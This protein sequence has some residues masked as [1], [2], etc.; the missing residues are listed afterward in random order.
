MA[1]IKIELDFREYLHEKAQQSRQ[2][3]IQACL[4]FLAGDLFFVGGILT[5][6]I[7]AGNIEWF[8]FIPYHPSLNTGPV[9]GLSL[10]I[11]GLCLMISG[12]IIGLY[13]Y[14]DRRGYIEELQK[15]YENEMRKANPMGQTSLPTRKRRIRRLGKNKSKGTG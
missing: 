7:L 9:L 12:T 8:L 5:N 3:E 10:I 15:A 11:S 14:Q 1:H 6:S 2:N 13:N 4:M